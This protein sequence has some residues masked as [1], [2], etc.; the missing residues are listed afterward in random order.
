MHQRLRDLLELASGYGL[1]L[2]VIWTPMPLQRILYWLT[3]VWIIGLT[4]LRHRS[5]QSLGLA[6]AGTLRSLWIVAT[7]MVLTIVAVLIAKQLG[8]F[9]PLFGNLPLGLHIWG[10]LVWA[11]LQEFMMQIY[12]L[13]RLLRLL[14]RRSLAVS[15][16]ALL[17]AVAHI[18]NPVLVGLT[19]IWGFIA[20]VLFLRYRNLYSLALAHAIL[21]ICVAIT[22][23]D[24]IH[25]H[26]RVGLG[27][28][29]YHQHRPGVQ[30]N[31]A[32]QTVSTQACV[33]A[34]AEMRLS[35]R[36]ARP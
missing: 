22:V 34:E 7:A 14:P 35:T 29:R 8:T 18:P 25:H 28:L 20:C 33:I 13:T 15:I 5:L 21:G 3:F 19:L 12:V 31:R 36:Q 26:M 27:Y 4:I 9:H 23:P 16:A 2:A 17:F 6:P 30:R 11:F 10:Y 1:I 32:P 24:A